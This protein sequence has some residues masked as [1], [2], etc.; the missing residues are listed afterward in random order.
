M[1]VVI[2]ASVALTWCFR[3]EARADLDALLFRIREDG[4]SA[5][6][7]GRLEVTNTLAAASRRGRLSPEQYGIEVRSL[8]AVPIRPDTEG[9]LDRMG[10]ILVLTRRHG[11]TVYD[12]TYLEL[13]KRLGRGLASL[14][15]QLRAAARAE[16]IPLIP[17]L[18]P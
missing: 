16:G 2:D 14:D 15:R 8:P 7:L 3:D 1:S 18:L 12:S 17:D 4:A 10:E 6:L 11:L 9:A 5:P 13:A